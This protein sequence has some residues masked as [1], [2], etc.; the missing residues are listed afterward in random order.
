MVGITKLPPG[1]V[2]R[3]KQKNI[4]LDAVRFFHKNKKD[5]TEGSKNIYLKSM[6]NKGD[7]E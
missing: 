6:L 7:S 2:K 4:Q 5:R 1:M 3:L